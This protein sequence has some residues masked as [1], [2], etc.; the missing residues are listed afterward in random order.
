MTGT[1]SA[2]KQR[3]KLLAL[4][5]VEE[6]HK[7]QQ[8]IDRIEHAQKRARRASVSAAEAKDARLNPATSV[9]KDVLGV[10]NRAGMEAAYTG[11]VL[12]GGVSILR[13]VVA[14]SKD[15]KPLGTAAVDV[16]VDTGKAAAGAY[17]AGAATAAVG[18][19]LQRTSSQV[20]Q[21]LGK[22]NAP[23]VA[24][25][26]AVMVGK[27]VMELARGRMTADQFVRSMTKDSSVLTASLT[28]S[29]LG[30]LVGTAVL[31]GVGTIIGGLVGGM[32]ASMLGGHLHMQLQQSIAALDASDAVRVRTQAIC[33]HIVTQHAAYQIEMRAAF[34]VFFSE[35]REE[36]KLGF[37]MV[38]L[39]TL[40]AGDPQEGLAVIASAMNSK[41]AFES[42]D[43]FSEH[44]RSGRA[45]TF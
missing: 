28:G 4:S 7:Q 26:A 22:S 17:V 38:A 30:A 18:G 2:L 44:I 5:K 37:D 36:L 15:G 40:D 23:A 9:A 32:A 41:L 6:A 21:N 1:D 34:D 43:S 27:N 25:Q 39:A 11:A 14:I 45:L 33:A 16:L 29:N 3:D 24:L 8:T 31:P 10:A 42:Q 13:N 20:F 19:A 12:G 35:K